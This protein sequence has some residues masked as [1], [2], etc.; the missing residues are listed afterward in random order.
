MAEE[1]LITIY[2][3]TGKALKVNAHVVACLKAGDKSLKG[4]SLTKPK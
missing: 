2:T 4:F 1:K 3:P